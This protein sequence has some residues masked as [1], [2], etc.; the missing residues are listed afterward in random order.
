[1]LTGSAATELQPSSG[2][3]NYGKGLL[4]VL[5]E[6]S[7]C[8]HC[9][10]HIFIYLLMKQCHL[11]PEIDSSLDKIAGMLQLHVHAILSSWKTGVFYI[12]CYMLPYYVCNTILGELHSQFTLETSM[13]IDMMWTLKCTT[14]NLFY[15]PRTL[16][17]IKNSHPRSDHCVCL[18]QAIQQ[19][20]NMQL[21][22][23]PQ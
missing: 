10:E 21:S 3:N 17:W 5:Y 4:E 22:Y 16:L 9:V 14:Y 18:L 20:N 13:L 8:L 23:W 15:A 12:A 1:M 7:N 19:E 11:L 6:F 2:A